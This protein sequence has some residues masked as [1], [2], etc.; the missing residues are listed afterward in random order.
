ML[1]NQTLA[2][3]NDS[4]HA[5]D[6]ET[7]LSGDE[8]KS[9]DTIFEVLKNRRR[10]LVLRYLKTTSES[11]SIGELAEHIAAIENDIKQAELGSQQRKRVYI[12]LYQSH[13]PKMDDAGVIQFDQNRGTI[14]LTE[15]ADSFYEYLDEMPDQTTPQRS[16]PSARRQCAAALATG[17]V[18]SVATVAGA[19]VV[20]SLAVLLFLSWFI[21]RTLRE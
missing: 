9:L 12:S 4:Q 6:H 19:T 11:A 2:T 17:I 3:E 14:S 16:A 21:F 1:T 5:R 10:R 20:A 15:T 13:L 18:Y 8:S 7:A